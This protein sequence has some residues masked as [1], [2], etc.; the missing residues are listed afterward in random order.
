MTISTEQ[1]ISVNVGA[2]ANDGTGDSIRNAFIKINQNFANISDVG[3]DAGNITVA[4]AVEAVGNISALYFVGDGRY[5]SNVGEVANYNDANVAAYLPSYSGNIG[6]LTVT[7]NLTVIGQQPYGDVDVA[8]YMSTYS[9]NM[10]DITLAGNLVALGTTTRKFTN[11]SAV[12]STSVT[13]DF[14]KG[15]TELLYL[16]VGA[17]ITIDYGAT[18][19]GGRQVDLTIKN[20]TGTS[21][22]AELPNANNNKGDANITLSSGTTSRL[23]FNAFGTTSSDIVVSVIND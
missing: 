4:G 23:V 21:W 14:N 15:G 20:S 7:G 2:T 6:N 5:L 16:S 8:N 12:N 3:F 10:F 1:F 9:G 22:V 13:L 19:T 11:N 17:N 18:I